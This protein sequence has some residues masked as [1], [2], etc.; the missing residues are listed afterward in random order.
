MEVATTVATTATQAI[1]RSIIERGKMRP[2][3]AL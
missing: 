2:I 3:D 1:E